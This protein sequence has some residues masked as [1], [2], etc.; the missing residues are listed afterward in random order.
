MHWNRMEEGKRN[1][2]Q[3]MEIGQEDLT[4]EGENFG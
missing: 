1:L 3:R 2:N 4:K